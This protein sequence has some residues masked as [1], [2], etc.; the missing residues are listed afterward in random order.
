M[1][2]KKNCLL[3]MSS[4]L[5]NQS[6]NASLIKYPKIDGI[7][8]ASIGFQVLQLALKKAGSTDQL[9]IS[10]DD[11]NQERAKTQLAD[12]SI[13]VFDTGPSKELDSQFETIY[14]PM[15]RGILGWR[16][17]IINK[18]N[19]PKF[20]NV[21]TINDLKAYKAGQGTGWG[22]IKT[23]EAAGISVMTATTI[24]DLVKMVE[25]KR[26]DFFPLGAN[27][28]Y[29]LL[30]KFGA[31]STTTEVE[32]SLTLVY[33]W[34]RFFYVKKGNEK[35]KAEITKGLDIALA[36]GSLQSLLNSHPMF[37][38]AFTTA[39]L[40]SRTVIKIESPNLPAGFSSI[41]KEW[42]FNPTK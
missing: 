20:A 21:K 28:V 18:E 23:L 41:P 29:G 15:D 12:G 31:G 32:K 25:G 1:S 24:K 2:F 39:N 38:D 4:I 42:W 13:D 8:E 36:D 34:A 16:L 11:V 30:E 33:P 9:V 5:I 37:K 10:G 35:L 14:R 40:S 17:F 27:E 22:D 7:G 6:I 19:A 3:I 26:F